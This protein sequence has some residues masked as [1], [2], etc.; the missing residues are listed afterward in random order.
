M[1]VQRCMRRSIS[2]IGLAA[3][4]A[5]GSAPA[6]ANSLDPQR[7]YQPIQS[8]LQ[9]QQ[10]VPLRL[11]SYI[12]D[13]KGDMKL[14]AHLTEV[15]PKGYDI[16]IGSPG[17]QFGASACTYANVSA[18][19]LTPRMKSPQEK[20]SFMDDPGYQPTKR[21]PSQ[22]GYVDLGN[23]IRGY[24]VPWVLGASVSN[25]KVIWQEDGIRYTVG[26]KGGKK[27]RVIRMAKSALESRR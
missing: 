2:S 18:Q 6:F 9:R 22:R 20:F 11:P 24:F 1:A 15:G 7:V 13:P 17:C 27:E 14:V 12:P 26:I 5:V 4:I 23:G 25:A 19:R 16:A 10:T 3:A 8:K 21:A